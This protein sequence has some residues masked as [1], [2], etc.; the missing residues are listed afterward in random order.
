MRLCLLFGIITKVPMNIIWQFLYVTHWPSA[1]S[2]ANK[3][4]I[5]HSCRIRWVA[6]SVQLLHPYRPCCST[7]NTE[8]KLPVHCKCTSSP[9]WMSL[10]YY[11]IGKAQIQAEL[12]PTILLSSNAMPQASWLALGSLSSVFLG[13]G[14]FS[15]VQDH[16]PPAHARGSF[17][18]AQR[19]ARTAH[20]SA[21]AH[22]SVHSKEVLQAVG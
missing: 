19:H 11:Y 14:L 6:V 20:W 4:Q 2:N 17:I 21:H 5:W 16:A 10:T 13:Y 12:K 18:P 22:R 8:K 15:H 3:V 9:E 1:A 7:R